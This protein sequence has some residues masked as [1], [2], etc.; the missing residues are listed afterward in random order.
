MIA[1]PPEESKQVLQLLSIDV[2]IDTA[3]HTCRHLEYL[4]L[5]GVPGDHVELLNLH[6]ATIYK[7]RTRPEADITTV[8]AMRAPEPF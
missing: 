7:A 2:M 6:L 1:A 4:L 8:K 3:Q 5:L